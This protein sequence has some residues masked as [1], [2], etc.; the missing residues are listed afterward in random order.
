MH[1]YSKMRRTVRCYCKEKLAIDQ[2]WELKNKQLEIMTWWIGHSTIITVTIKPRKKSEYSYC[3]STIKEHNVRDGLIWEWVNIYN[4]HEK[5]LGFTQSTQN[6]QLYVQLQF[7]TKR[8]TSEISK[9]LLIHN[10]STL[11]SPHPPVQ[12]PGNC[13]TQNLQK[14]PVTWLFNLIS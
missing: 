2:T 7:I 5:F 4:V 10:H 3:W 14:L 13:K 8:Q 9:P 11:S 12:G 1:A 6:M